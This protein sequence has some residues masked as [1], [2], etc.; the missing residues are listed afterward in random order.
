MGAVKSL[1]VDV[2]RCVIAWTSFCQIFM[3]C[4]TDRYTDRFTYMYHFID[5]IT[6]LYQ[7]MGDL[8]QDYESMKRVF[9]IVEN[10]KFEY[11]VSCHLG[12]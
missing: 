3:L 8:R 9:D 4:L 5:T 6:T 7:E 11:A 12:K 2:R 10:M 1:R